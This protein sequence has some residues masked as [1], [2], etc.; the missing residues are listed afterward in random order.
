MNPEKL[1]REQWYELESQYNKTP[2]QPEDKE[3]FIS[4]SVCKSDF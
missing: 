2:A 1:T 4:H 3:Y